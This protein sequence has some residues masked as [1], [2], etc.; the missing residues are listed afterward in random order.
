[1]S[2]DA[3]GS[4][5]RVRQVDVPASVRERS[6]LTRIDYADTFLVDIGAAQVTAEQCARE[7]LEGAPLAIRTQLLSGWSSIG[8]KISKGS[9]PHSVLGWPVRQNTPD[10]ILLGAD[11]RI[12]MPGRA[13]VQQGRRYV[14]V[15][16][17]CAPRQPTRPRGVGNDRAGSCPDGAAHPRPS[18]PTTDR[19]N[20]LGRRRRWRHWRRR[21]RQRRLRARGHAR[22][23][24]GINVHPALR[25][26]EQRV[27]S[28]DLLGLHGMPELAQ[29]GQPWLGRPARIIDSSRGQVL[30]AGQVWHLR[31]G[32]RRRSGIASGLHLRGRRRRRRRDG[33]QWLSQR[34]RRECRRGDRP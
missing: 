12:G 7:V 2:G 19:R 32:R 10:F 22:G 14:V 34:R 20:G 21:R 29:I 15:R 23:R 4:A 5:G 27:A 13:D 16:K 8:L 25:E 6:T 28:A 9:P 33:Y 26:Q 11:S 3:I 30:G 1:M 31:R 18:R 24:R 17:P